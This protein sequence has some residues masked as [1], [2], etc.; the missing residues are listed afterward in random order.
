MKNQLKDDLRSGTFF[1]FATSQMLKKANK[2]DL[3]IIQE[4]LS[5]NVQ[6]YGELIVR[7]QDRLFNSLFRF[8]GHEED[9]SD[10]V[11]EAFF[12]AFQALRDFQGGSRFYTWLYRIAMNL[13]IDQRRRQSKQESTQMGKRLLIQ[14][15]DKT[16]LDNPMILAMRRE[17]IESVQKALMK[18]SH[19]HR[20]VLILKD[21]EG[22]HYEEIAEILSIPIGTVRSRI[23]RARLELRNIIDSAPIA[24]PNSTAQE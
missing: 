22:L 15:Q 7:Y 2:D 16:L 6:A 5:G 3:Q 4:C 11:Q 14:T 10:V 13:A 17:N 23:H 18:L 9:A 24:E 19:D 12:N 20:S 1:R 8:L 21:I